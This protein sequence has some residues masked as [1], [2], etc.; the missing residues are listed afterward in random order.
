MASVTI[1]SLVD[2]IVSPST[3]ASGSQKRFITSV[4]PLKI[5]WNLFFVDS[6]TDVFTNDDTFVSR[7]AAPI[8][9]GVFPLNS[10]LLGTAFPGSVSL[11]TTLTSAT[12][13]TV[14]LRDI[15]ATGCDGICVVV[16]G[17]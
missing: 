11:D 1:A 16:F 8:G 7:L 9:A 17:F 4:G 3:T 12:Y 15:I 6:D 13:K 10:D 5:E 14:T 2:G